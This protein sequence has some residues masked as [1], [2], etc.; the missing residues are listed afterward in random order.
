MYCSRRQYMSTFTAYF[1]DGDNICRLLPR[2]HTPQPPLQ[3][4]TTV[5]A[6][7]VAGDNMWQWATTSVENSV[8]F[9]YPK[10]LIKPSWKPR[11]SSD[12]KSEAAASPGCK[13]KPS[14]TDWV[15]N[16]CNLTKNKRIN[17]Y[18]GK[19]YH[20][21][22]VSEKHQQQKKKKNQKKPHRQCVATR[23]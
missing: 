10:P 18:L 16:I 11:Y 9:L 1:V 2:T 17:T 14:R 4:H 5:V 3:T 19:W 15:W 21:H 20:G 13:H 8:F 7:I 12:F 22:K 6:Y 23:W